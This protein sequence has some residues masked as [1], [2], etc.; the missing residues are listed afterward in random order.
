MFED[1]T[2]E[3][4]LLIIDSNQTRRKLVTS[5]LSLKYICDENE[6]INAALDQIRAKEYAVIVTAFAMHN[7]DG[8]AFIPLMQ[9]ISPRS[10][11]IFISDNESAGNTVRAFRAGAFEVIQKPFE[12]KK[13][14][15]AVEKAFGQYEMKCLKDS[16]QYHL[17]ELVS[18]RTAELDKALEEIEN[19]YRMTLKALV[20]ALETRDFETHGHSETSRYIFPAARL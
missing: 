11:L 7:A 13:I 16:Y 9:K 19:S 4:N 6:E 2:C 15:L 5:F 10:V 14:E 3:K 12:L 18:E 17:E 20:Q 1:F 8:P